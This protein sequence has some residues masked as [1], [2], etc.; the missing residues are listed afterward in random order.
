MEK[1]HVLH[2]FTSAPNLSPFDANM[3]AD[4]GWHTLV[5]YTSLALEDVPAL[6]QDAMFSRSPS[7]LKRT[8]IFIGGRDAG[9]AL[10]MLEQARKVMFPPFQMSVFAD[11][12]GAF[13]TA[14]G[15][16][17]A[18]EARLRRDHDTDWRGAD[19]L[20]L[21]GTGPVGLAAAILAS[22]LG[23]SVTIMSRSAQRAEAAADKCRAYAGDG[24][25][26]AGGSLAAAAEADKAARLAQAD[27]VLATAAAGIEMLSADEI[28]GAPLLKV[29]ADVNAVPPSGVA[30]LKAH[31]DGEPLAGSRSGAVGVGALAI[32]NVKY[33]VQHRLLKSMHES[34]EPLYLHYESACE[35]AR[36]Y[37]V[38][39]A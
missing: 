13:T 11:P 39:R 3:A 19:V 9:V 32:G 24:A 21:G 30:G 5:P 18:V 26:P 22:Q 1:F 17:A 37:A 31:H 4:A 33:Q 34:D 2:M 12:S 10:E 38:Q 6:V 15:M 8:G 25:A 23:S 36:A 16:I 20:I 35:A 14:A 29:A 27:V 28:A 7:G